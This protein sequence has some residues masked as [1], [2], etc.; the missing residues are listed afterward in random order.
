MEV[1]LLHCVY[2]QSHGSSRR[3]FNLKDANLELVWLEL[4]TNTTETPKFLCVESHMD[5]NI[6]SN[7]GGAILNSND[8]RVATAW[9]KYLNLTETNPL[10][11]LPQALS[12]I[13]LNQRIFGDT[14]PRSQTCLDHI[15]STSD[16]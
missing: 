1:E 10:P 2:K 15:Y 3:C 6:V 14:C 5:S 9:C 12:A 7:L 4:R 11:F 13:R 8:R 16:F